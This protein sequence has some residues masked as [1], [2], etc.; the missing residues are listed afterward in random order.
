[1]KLMITKREIYEFD[2]DKLASARI[3]LRALRNYTALQAVPT[4][5][6]IFKDI[7]ECGGT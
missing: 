2:N 3:I 6:T 4:L 7:I 1:M 5:S